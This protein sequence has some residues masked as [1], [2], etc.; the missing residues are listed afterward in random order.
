MTMMI[1]NKVPLIPIKE[2]GSKRVVTVFLTQ[3]KTEKR[4]FRCPA[5]GWVIAQIESE[6]ALI[7]DADQVPEGSA[8]VDVKC[9]RCHLTVRFLL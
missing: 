2:D 4:N 9:R 5:C 3:H 6:I 1:K 8:P 7:I